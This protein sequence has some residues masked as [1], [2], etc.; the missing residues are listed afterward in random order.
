M[1]LGNHTSMV[2]KNRQHGILL[3]LISQLQ[4]LK[5][6]TKERS[7]QDGDDNQNRQNYTLAT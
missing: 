3:H 1:R 4:P 5:D 2:L 6:T 7:I